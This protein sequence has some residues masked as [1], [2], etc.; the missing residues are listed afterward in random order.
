MTRS[1]WAFLSAKV[2]RQR[3]FADGKWKLPVAAADDYSPENW[4]WT[5]KKSLKKGKHLQTTIFS[6]FYA[7]FRGCSPH[8]QILTLRFCTSLNAPKG[9]WEPEFFPY[10]SSNQTLSW[11]YLMHDFAIISFILRVFSPILFSD[12]KDHWTLQWKGLNLYSR[13]RVLKMASFEGSGYLGQ[14]SKI[15]LQKRLPRC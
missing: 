2:G 14:L 9:I 10:F 12:P 4:L 15:L 8:Q 13:G 3:T 1:K 6:R 7:S 5:W 11:K